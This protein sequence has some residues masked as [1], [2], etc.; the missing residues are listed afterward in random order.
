MQ[1]LRK[2]SGFTLMEVIIALTITAIISA[3]IYGSFSRTFDSREF[4]LQA[5][6][7]YQTVRAAL[8]RMS[9]EISMAFIY[10]CRELDTPTGEHRYRTLFKVEREGKIDHMIFSS[11]SHLRLFRDAHESDQNILAYFGEPDSE[12][13]SK[14]NL[15][16]R[17]KTRIDE[18]PEEGGKA[19]VL[20][21]HIEE[22]R[23]EL[24]DETKEDWV[25]E[26]DCSQVEQLN[27]LPNMVR[28]TLSVIDEY[29]E[30]IPF[31]TIARIFTR[32]PLANWIKPSQ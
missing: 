13:S 4:V 22:L 5:Q 17:E 20:C 30:E 23:F 11:F 8:E 7:R 6:E 19:F 18:E 27:R 3:M 14:T 21:P 10:D 9:R 31:T 29:G 1:L 2:H 12:D 25:D 15:M 26:W 32:Q 24:W 28:I 16:R